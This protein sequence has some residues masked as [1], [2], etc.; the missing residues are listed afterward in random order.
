MNVFELF[1]KLSLDSSEYE[2]GLNES[3]KDAQSFGSKLKSGLGKAAKIGAGAMAAVGTA[4][5]AAGAVMVKEA[6]AVAAHGDQIDKM[7]QKLGL[8]SEAY[9][10]W[11]YVLGQSGADIN[12]MSAGMK[13]LTN[14]LDEA[15][16]GSE[17]AQ[18]MFAKL[19]I[20][21]D[22]INKM[23]REELFEAS[24]KG[25]Q[26]MADSTERAALANDLFGKSGQELT[27]LFNT[28]IEE[29]EALLQASKDLGFVMSEESVAAA[30][31]YQDALDTMQRTMGGVKT[32]IVSDFLPGITSVMDGLTKIFAGDSEE[33][34]S[35]LTEGIN[36][37]FT[38]MEEAIP[39]IITVGGNIIS[40]LFNALMEN[41]PQIAQGGTEILIQLVNALITAVPKLIPAAVTMIKTIA[42][43]LVENFPKLI[44]TGKKAVA[45]L[46]GGM[47][48]AELIRKGGELLQKLVEK[49]LTYMPVL[50][51]KGVDFIT[52]L[53]NGIGQNA[54][55][56]LAAITEVVTNLISTIMERLPEFLEQ[57]IG[58]IQQM[59]EGIAENLPT[60]VS[61]M[62]EM[63][64]QLIATIAE[65]LPEFLSKGFELVTEMAA[66]LISAIPDIVS[67]AWDLINDFVGAFDEYDWLSI[68]TNIIDGIINGLWNMA[69]SLWDAI[70]GVVDNA[71]GGLLSWLGIASPSKKAEKEIGRNWAEGIG[72]GFDKNMPVADMIDSVEGAFDEINDMEPVIEPVYE[73]NGGTSYGG[74][75]APVINVY[76]AEG[77]DI[78][79]LADEIMDR[80]TFLYRQE[81]VA[82]A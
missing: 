42:Q 68:G 48:P 51:Q 63:L 36:K 72:V 82:Y 64:A 35:I 23:S 17:D 12:S 67:G 62:A 11:D 66:G 1:A 34:G 20:S 47:S 7:S 33:G 39:K 77:Q 8:S 27:P 73:S 65:N 61:S 30:A 54:P 75:F 5:A 44:E 25:F 59:A 69:G 60:I 37:M 10:Q 50:L 21:M 55:E 38:T 16:G 58:L 32:S 18:K 41:I 31:D 45:E 57:G 13:T 29:T 71:W 2:E 53:S 81:S 14:K 9:Q 43:T 80:M 49:I 56:I 3:E 74:A 79:E 70:V 78:S 15:K 40:S 22:D 6:G 52:N 26:G 4:A 76:G 19:G 24:I 28:S 46:A